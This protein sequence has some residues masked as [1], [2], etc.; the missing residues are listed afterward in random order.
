MLIEALACLGEGT[1]AAPDQLDA[2]LVFGIGFPPFRGGLLHY[3][4]GMPRDEA[5]KLISGLGLELPSN[6]DAIHG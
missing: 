4:A 2:A 5:G 6:L 3:F 1:V